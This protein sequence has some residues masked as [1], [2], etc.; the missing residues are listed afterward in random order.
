MVYIASVVGE[1]QKAVKARGPRRAT[2]LDAPSR[3]DERLEELGLS[4]NQLAL[5]V[6]VSRQVMGRWMSGRRPWP[7]ARA[8]QVAEL[9]GLPYTELFEE[10]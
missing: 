2:R 9:V 4:W 7:R 10:G 1:T 6:G 8:A 5:Q 3:L